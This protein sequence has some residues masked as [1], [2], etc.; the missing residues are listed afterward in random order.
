VSKSTNCAGVSEKIFPFLIPE[1]IA[2][3]AS[4]MLYSSEEEPTNNRYEAWGGYHRERCER[5]AT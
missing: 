5:D 3:Y 2:C 1:H 4:L